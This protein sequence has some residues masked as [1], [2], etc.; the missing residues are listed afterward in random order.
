MNAVLAE[1]L[2]RI[3]SKGKSPTARTLEHMRKRGYT[4]QVVEHWNNFSRRR[5]D[6]FGFIDVLCVKGED[7]VGVQAC[8]AGGSSKR[9]SDMSARITKIVEHDNW[10]LVCK[11]IRIIVQGWRKSAKGR[12][13]VREV[14]LSEGWTR[15][16]KN[17]EQPA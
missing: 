11:A 4:C 7:I 10:P 13:E 16:T 15:E 14:E 3:K 9:G 17:A 5:V 8:S 1:R 2:P 6:L 12:W